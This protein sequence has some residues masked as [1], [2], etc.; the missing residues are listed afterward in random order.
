MRPDPND[1]LSWLRT[2]TSWDEGAP[3]MQVDEGP[4]SAMGS[5]AYFAFIP[6]ESIT[7]GIPGKAKPNNRQAAEK[8][9]C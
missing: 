2:Q 1:F 5:G 7:F 9:P 8:A 6:T 3:L 4:V